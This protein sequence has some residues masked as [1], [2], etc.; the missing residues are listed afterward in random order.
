MKR[1]TENKLSLQLIGEMLDKG[2]DAKEY[3]RCFVTLIQEIAGK[4]SI[5]QGNK[6][7]IPC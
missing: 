7:K 3:K 6:Q 2:F 4:Q 5:R 1:N